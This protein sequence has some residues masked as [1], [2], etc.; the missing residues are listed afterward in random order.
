MKAPRLATLAPHDERLRDVTP[1]VKA[2]VAAGCEAERVEVDKEGTTVVVTGKG[3][4][5]A[6]VSASL[7]EE[8]GKW[9]P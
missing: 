8:I 5:G 9:S 1:A 3:G 6:T 4:Q 7:T 2:V